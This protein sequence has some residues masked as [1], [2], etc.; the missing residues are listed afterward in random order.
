ML[1]PRR[2]LVRSSRAVDRGVFGSRRAPRGARVNRRGGRELFLKINGLAKKRL[3][4]G[5]AADSQEQGRQAKVETA[6][7]EA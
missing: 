3:Q 2:G 1:F 7:Q 6:K 5:G 4:T